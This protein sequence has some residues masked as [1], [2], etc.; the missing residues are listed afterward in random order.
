MII[1]VAGYQKCD[2]WWWS[3]KIN[4]AFW[5]QH[6]RSLE[7]LSFPLSLVNHRWS[8][9]NLLPITVSRC[10]SWHVLKKHSGS[11]IL[12]LMTRLLSYWYLVTERKRE[13]LAGFYQSSQVSTQKKARFREFVAYFFE[14]ISLSMTSIWTEMLPCNR[15]DFDR[16]LGAIVQDLDQQHNCGCIETCLQLLCCCLDA[17]RFKFK[18][19][20]HRFILWVLIWLLSV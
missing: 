19:P 17:G 10:L 9:V 4:M 20:D 16:P 2:G 5:R 8:I 18:S 1:V 15:L 6:S 7:G 14:D 13:S 3:M 11:R 12:R